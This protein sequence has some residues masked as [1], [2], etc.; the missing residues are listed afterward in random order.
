M[1]D[2]AGVTALLELVRQAIIARTYALQQYVL[3]GSGTNSVTGE[4]LIDDFEIDRVP[5]GGTQVDGQHGLA[6]A[7]ITVV[8]TY[9]EDTEIQEIQQ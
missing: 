1:A 4:K 3:A 9:R 2:A 5:S 7:T 8:Y 6:L